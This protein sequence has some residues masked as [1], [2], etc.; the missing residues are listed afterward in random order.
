MIKPI[1]DRVVVK[2]QEA[3]STTASG[4][5][6]PNNP[7]QPTTGKVIYVGDGS[8]NKDGTTNPMQVQKGDTVVFN[9]FAGTEIKIKDEELLVMREDDVIGIIQ[10]TEQA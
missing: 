4:I 1:G 10:E 9:K 6:L 2:R 3:D 5:V 8:R 7:D